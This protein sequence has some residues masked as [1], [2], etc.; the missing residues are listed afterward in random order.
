MDLEEDNTGAGGGGREGVLPCFFY[1]EAGNEARGQEVITSDPR[2]RFMDRPNAA[3]T[4][5]NRG[6]DLAE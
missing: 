5:F 2:E 4:D 1:K 6:V 3:P